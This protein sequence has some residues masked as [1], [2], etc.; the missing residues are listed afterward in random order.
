[1]YLRLNKMYLQFEKINLLL[2]W[3]QD[4]ILSKSELSYALDKYTQLSLTRINHPSEEYFDNYDLFIML[5]WDLQ[6]KYGT[7]LSEYV[8][9]TNEP[10]LPSLFWE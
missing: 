3:F 10:K 4:G 1:M 7:P 9:R 5:L 8:Y 6:V 2:S